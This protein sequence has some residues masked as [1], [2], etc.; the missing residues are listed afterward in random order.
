VQN[1]KINLKEISIQ[2][3]RAIYNSCL[4]LSLGCTLYGVTDFSKKLIFPEF[5]YIIATFC[6]IQNIYKLMKAN[7][8]N[9]GR[10]ATKAV[11]KDS[12]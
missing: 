1:E 11:H 2:Y 7:D 9:L 4:T 12:R 3:F 5:T 8:V 6:L 10:L